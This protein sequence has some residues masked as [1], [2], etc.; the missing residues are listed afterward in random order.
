MY[1][2]YPG[3]GAEPQ[4]TADAT[5]TPTPPPSIQTA[6]RLMY[7]GAAVE[8]VAFIVTL[9]ASGSR[10]A[11]I[12]KAHPGYTAAEVHRSELALTIPL[13]IGALIAIALWVWMAR[14]NGRG[15]SWARV[16]AAVLFGINTID[17]LGSLALV[18]HGTTL[19]AGVPTLIV[20][21]VI[22]LIG[23]AAIVLLFRKDSTSYYAART[24]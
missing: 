6:V 8:V 12:V 19:S 24:P 1:E 20:A 21:V 17:T 18:R 11:A 5:L 4:P 23:L 14:A 2:P 13:A 22:W 3:T 9:V 15:R 16:L 7:A 10:R